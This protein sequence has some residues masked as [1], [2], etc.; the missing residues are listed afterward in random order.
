MVTK[1]LNV[2][3]IGLEKAS[4][5][6]KNGGIVGIPTET[7]YGLAANAYNSDAITKIFK[8]KGRPQDNPLI[9][10]IASIDTLYEIAKDIPKTAL[11]CAE[12]FWPGP[13][14]MVLK[15]TDKIP[16]AVSA[17]LSTVAV[18]MPKNKTARELILKSGLPLAAPSANTSGS[19]SPT[20]AN[21]VITD[22]DGK[23]DAVLMGESCTVGVESTVIT[24]VGEHPVLLRPGGVTLEQLKEVLPDITIS[25]AVLNELKKSET[26]LKNLV[27]N[28]FLEDGLDNYSTDKY[29]LTLTKTDNT[30]INM[31]K[32]IVS[33]MEEYGKSKL[34]SLGVFEEKIYVNEERLQES[35]FKHL[36][37]CS[38]VYTRTLSKPS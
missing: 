13:L 29:K 3:N 36:T 2:D 26:E 38:L 14:T 7:V 15:K 9:V 35:S 12:K 24:L 31:E 16:L 11:L 6:L 19:P 21:H 25:D 30:S 18:R 27:K 10:H 1:R 22:L 17:G 33:L 23:I 28:Q 20:T 8:A 37:I 34:L 5:I 4:E 32:L